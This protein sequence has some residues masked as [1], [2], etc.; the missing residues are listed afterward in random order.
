[1]KICVIGAGSIG[2]TRKLIRDI[3][4]VPEFNQLEIS[5]MDISAENLE[6][7]YKLVARDIEMNACGAR[8]TKTT[9]RRSA[10]SGAKY[11]INTCRIG[12]LEAYE[13]DIE[14]PLS[15]GIDQ[16]VGDTLGAGGIMYG[17]RGIPVVLDF[18]NDIRELAAPDPVFLNYANPNAMLTWAANTWGKVETIGLCHGVQHSAEML[19]TALGIPPNE[20]D[21][22]CVGIN[23]QTWF[24]K[25]LHKGEDMQGKILAA[26]EAHD[27]YSRNEKVRIDMLRRFGYFSTETSGHLSEYL[28][29]YRKTPS[30]VKNWYSPE[31]WCH[32]ETGGYLR[33]CRESR[34]LFENE[35][36]RWLSE[37]P[38][39]YGPG[40]RSV[41]HGSFIMEGLETG[42]TYRGHFNLINNGAIANLPP[43]CVVEVPAYATA[44]GIKVPSAGNLPWQCASVCLNSV[45][46]QRLAVEAAVEG[47]VEKL[48]YAM[49]LDPLNGAVLNTEQVCNLTEDMLLAQEQWLPQYKE[50]ISTLKAKGP[51]PAPPCPGYKGAAPQDVRPLTELL[52]EWEKNE[53][54]ADEGALVN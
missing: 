3:L 4:S 47:N 42:R 40:E 28:A 2:F 41:E 21:Y 25:L 7:V 24:V 16:C 53:K 46:V 5:L 31:A 8:L 33:A 45:N 50:E 35:Y 30:E 39:K 27:Y 9:D 32:G 1:M 13:T 18:C 20:L 44:T 26:L 37:P 14:V 15:Y 22:D 49:L 19:A 52:K 11:I 17:Q 10:I 34:L 29:W 36:D 43:D 51:R 54:V 6:M 23:H 38:L 48:K 12:G